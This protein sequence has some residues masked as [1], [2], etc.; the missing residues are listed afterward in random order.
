M[1][2]VT[3]GSNLV[4]LNVLSLYCLEKELSERVGSEAVAGLEIKINLNCFP[5][6]FR[7]N[8]HVKQEDFEKREML[9]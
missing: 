5:S 9:S 2:A 3:F 6:T 1:S 7:G 8:L 4:D